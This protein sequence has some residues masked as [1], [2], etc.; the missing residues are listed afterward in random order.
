M[1]SK[2][3]EK[4]NRRKKEGTYRSLFDFEGSIDFLSN[5]YLGFA[6]IENNHKVKVFGSTGSRL[7]SGNS[8]EAVACEKVLANFFQS[9]AALVFNSGYDANLGFFSCIPQKGDTVIYDENMHASVRDGIRMSF[10]NSFSFKHNSLDDLRLKLTKSTGTVYVAVESLYSMDGDMAPLTQIAILVNEFSAFLI[11]DEAHACGVFGKKGK[12]IVDALELNDK[13]FARIITFGKAYGS[14]GACVIGEENLINYLI[15]FA[16]SFIYTTALPPENYLRIGK[17][18][19]SELIEERQKHLHENIAY[20]RE[21]MKSDG[22]ISEI[23]SPIQMLRIGNIPT[24]QKLANLL[25]D[26]KIAV[27]PI[28][29]PTVSV[30]NESIRIC[31]HSFNTFEEI[32]LLVELVKES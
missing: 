5:D 12:G 9:E 29:S 22:L 16:R 30:G 27:K 24:T 4:L 15:N 11:V 6:K 8:K 25:R 26:N 20:F 17:M 10:A 19:Q 13:I 31:I 7:I 28:F 14:H 21:K 2:L 18:V 32:D 23:N 1:D 3:I